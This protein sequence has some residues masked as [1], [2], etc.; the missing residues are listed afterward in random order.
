MAGPPAD[1]SP[2]RLFRSLLQ[3][4]RPSALVA[5][6]PTGANNIALTCRAL[7]A[8]EEAAAFDAA[9]S[10]P[11]GAW[12]SRVSCALVAASVWAGD[13][14]AFSC[15]DGVASL[16]APVADA[17]CREV[18]AI[19]DR[20]S[21]SYSRPGAGEWI[22]ALAKGAEHPENFWIMRALAYEDSPTS[23]FGVP[24]RDMTDGQWMCFRASRIVAEKQKS[25]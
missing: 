3:T 11:P 10:L 7:T 15:A 2:E 23:Y 1:V 6:R 13:V 25:A 9:N 20:I 12:G 19:L 22:A 18:N 21:P 8:L 17:L 4:P 16:P 24:L 14:R 5:W